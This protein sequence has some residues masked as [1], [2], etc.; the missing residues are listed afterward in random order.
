MTLANTYPGTVPT[1]PGYNQGGYSCL[2]PYPTT[3]F[4]SVAPPYQDP[5]AGYGMATGLSPSGT[6]IASPDSSSIKTDVR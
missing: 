5:L 4:S 6:T 2:T 1:Y 3:T